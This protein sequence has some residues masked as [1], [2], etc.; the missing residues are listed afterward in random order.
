VFERF[1][2]H[3]RKVV[4]LAQEEARQLKHN[5]IGTEHIPLGLAREKRGVACRVLLTF[6]VSPKMVRNA[7]VRMLAASGCTAPAV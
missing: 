1:T 7:V 5:H 3:A 2:P 6:E 4:V